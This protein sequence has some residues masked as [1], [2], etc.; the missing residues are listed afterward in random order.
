MSSNF[1]YIK[2]WK[3]PGGYYKDDKYIKYTGED[4]PKFIENHKEFIESNPNG[5]WVYVCVPDKHRPERFKSKFDRF[6]NKEM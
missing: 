5:W 2:G 6:K 1:K 4:D 3:F